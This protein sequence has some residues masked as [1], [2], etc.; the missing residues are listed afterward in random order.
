[1]KHLYWCSLES[2]NNAEQIHSV[3]FCMKQENWQAE[4][5]TNFLNCT[6]HE[7]YQPRT[8]KNIQREA[9]LYWHSQE[10]C[11]GIVMRGNRWTQKMTEWYRVSPHPCNASLWEYLAA[12]AAGALLPNPFCMHTLPTMSLWSSCLLSVC[13]VMQ[14][15]KPPDSTINH[16]TDQ[17]VMQRKKLI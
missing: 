15:G 9:C 11:R 6:I 13:A 2:F 12:T 8:N 10:V 7:K 3:L 1:M 16:R 5:D 17:K 4:S 14:Q